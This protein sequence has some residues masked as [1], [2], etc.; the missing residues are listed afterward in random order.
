MLKIFHF[1]I[2]QIWRSIITKTFLIVFLSDFRL[3]GLT[4]HLS[5]HVYI[6]Y[7]YIYKT[8]L[9]VTKSLCGFVANQVQYN[10]EIAQYL[11]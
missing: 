5:A 3:S 7:I 1:I 9:V 6:I 11:G 4:K 2:F 10:T 8:V